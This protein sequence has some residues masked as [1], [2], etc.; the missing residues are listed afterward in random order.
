MQALAQIRQSVSSL[1]DKT[2]AK[3]IAAS[4]IQRSQTKTNQARN[5]CALHQHGCLAPG[6]SSGPSSASLAAPVIAWLHYQLPTSQHTPAAAR[7]GTGMRLLS[8]I[9]LAFLT[10]FSLTWLIWR[11]FGMD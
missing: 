7:P 11:L 4:E 10:A 3:C 5:H 6:L 9:G 2:N 8:W 1:P